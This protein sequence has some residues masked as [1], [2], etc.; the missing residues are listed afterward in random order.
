MTI[1]TK[2]LDDTL[3]QIDQTLK[4]HERDEHFRDNRA[5][6][7][8]ARMNLLEALAALREVGGSV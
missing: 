1:S 6:L 7:L 3:V 8:W 5:T 4:D 2:P